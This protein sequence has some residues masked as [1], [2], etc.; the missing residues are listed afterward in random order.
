MAIHTARVLCATQA[1]SGRPT[2]VVVEL[3][4]RAVLVRALLC[5][6]IAAAPATPGMPLEYDWQPASANVV[7]RPLCFGYGESL[8]AYA[9]VGYKDRATRHRRQVVDVIGIADG[10]PSV[11]TLPLSKEEIDRWLAARRFVPGHSINGTR[12]VPGN[13]MRVD[14]ARVRYDWRVHEGDASYENFGDMTVRCPDGR[15]IPL[16]VRERGL[17]L[18]E[19]ALAFSRPDSDVIAIS[20]AGDDGGEGIVYHWVNTLIVDLHRLCV[21]GH[22]AIAG[23]VAGRNLGP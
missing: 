5:V 15:E 1:V 22:V 3:H 23:P 4:S 19:V 11:Q 13:W 9:C 6:A 21:T 12:L 18:G 7:P 20:V 17:E 8:R 16:G 10:Q 2:R 14:G